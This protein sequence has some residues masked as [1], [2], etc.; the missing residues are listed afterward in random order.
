M[1]VFVHLRFKGLGLLCFRRD[2][3]V[4]ITVVCSKRLPPPRQA[5]SLSLSLL[6]L[7]LSRRRLLC[8]I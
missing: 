3:V 5:L 1:H 8:L 4:L 7:S 6:V 2:M